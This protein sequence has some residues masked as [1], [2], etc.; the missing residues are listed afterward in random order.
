VRGDALLGALPTFVTQANALEVNVDAKEIAVNTNAISAAANA[1]LAAANATATLWVSGTTYAI[2]DIR[3]SPANAAPY[4]RLTTGAGVTDPS[5]D[6][7]NWALF[8]VAQAATATLAATATTA[9]NVAYSGLTGTVPTWNQS[10]TGNAATA[11]T[12]TNVAY[13]G[14]TGTVPTWNQSTT[15]NAATVTN[16]V[17]TVGAQTIAG[18]KTF[19]DGV[20]ASSSSFAA[21]GVVSLGTSY[22]MFASGNDA[23]GI[24]LNG[25]LGGMDIMANQTNQP[26]RFWAGGQNNAPTLVATL[27]NT[28]FTVTSNVTA[29]NLSGTNTGDQSYVHGA[30]GTYA[31]LA[32]TVTRA[33]G[34]S[35]AGSALA[36]SS[37]VNISSTAAFASSGSPSTL[38][39]TWRCMS[40]PIVIGASTL[41][42]GLFLRI[43]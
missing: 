22:R 19:T 29:A 35:V 14:L 8:V 32:T 20:L 34:D 4:R 26:I 43:S 18:V 1:A 40:N 17:Y 37:I 13:S 10:T 30:V 15:G 33:F 23:Y 36:A 6:A 21:I 41:G 27:S 11:T 39:G 42:H 31:L 3:R 38:S 5:A 25:P 28:G 24:G 9:T 16:G 2:A 12:A 7:V